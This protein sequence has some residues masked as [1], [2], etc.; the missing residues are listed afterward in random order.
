LD[1]KKIDE[2]V[3]EIPRGNVIGIWNSRD[4]VELQKEMVILVLKDQKT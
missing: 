4:Y 2:A 3:L 1:W